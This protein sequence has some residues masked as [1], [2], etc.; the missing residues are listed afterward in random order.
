MPNPLTEILDDLEFNQPFTA[1]VISGALMSGRWTYAWVQQTA[2][3][4]G[5]TFQDA[6]PAKQGSYSG[7]DLS[8]FQPA[9][10]RNNNF[11]ILQRLPCQVQMQ[12]SHMEGPQPVYVFDSPKNLQCV[13]TEVVPSGSIHYENSQGSGVDFSLVTFQSGN[14]IGGVLTANSS[15]DLQYAEP[16][17]SGQ[18]MLAGSFRF[19]DPPWALSG[20]AGGLTSGSVTSGFLGNASVVSGSIGS[21][22]I[23]SVHLASGTIPA[24]PL[25]SGSVLPFY[26]ASGSVNGFFGTSP[27]FH[28]ASGTIGKFDLGSG[29]IQQGQFNAKAVQSGDIDTQVLAH[30]HI[31]SGGIS[32]GDIANAAIVRNSLASGIIGSGCVVSGAMNSG[33]L[34][35]GIPTNTKFLRGDFQWQDPSLT[36]V[37]ASGSVQSGAIASGAVQGFFG[38]TRNISSGTVG[39]YDFG[40]GAVIAGALGSGAVVSGSIAS[41]QVGTNHIAQQ[42]ILSGQIAS[43]QVAI[44]HLASGVLYYTDRSP[45]GRLTTTSDPVEDLSTRTSG[46]NWMPYDSDQVPLWDT[47]LS[48]W[49]TV[50]C[51]G[52]FWSMSGATNANSGQVWDIWGYLNNGTMV[53]SGTSWST[54]TARVAGNTPAYI[55]GR[56]VHPSGMG[57]YLGTIFQSHSGAGVINDPHYRFVWNQYNRLRRKVRFTDTGVLQWNYSG[58]TFRQ[59]NA[60]GYNQFETVC[61]ISGHSHVHLTVSFLAGGTTSGQVL[62][63]IGMDATN[64]GDTDCFAMQFNKT[65]AITEAICAFLDKDMPAGYHYFP[66]LEYNIAGQQTTWFGG[67]VNGAQYG[68]IG[69]VET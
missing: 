16:S 29:A 33:N 23:G 28:V 3:A 55:A 68:M 51:S 31:A 56:Y 41:G 50:R 14:T 67:A 46:I 20:A 65:P 2:G 40:S 10:E 13:I 54:T 63:S 62:V 18:V 38:S 39:V 57:L 42:A 48:G 66:S 37:L 5:S 59:T 52:A 26:L 17:A 34:G 32:S 69:W 19:I 36:L 53:L 43:G 49:V 35:V 22:Q 1:Q 60:S 47:T 9:Y 21:G 30:P 58:N 8:V 61:G 4:S 44:N 24:T 15:G 27:R 7:L 45:G 12:F 64:S 11:L 6:V 25:T